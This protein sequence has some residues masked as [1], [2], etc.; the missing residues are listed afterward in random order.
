M[1]IL[2]RGKRQ[3][4]LPVS[5]QGEVCQNKVCTSANRYL[6]QLDKLMT[7]CWVNL[8]Q[9]LVFFDSLDKSMPALRVRAK[10]LQPGRRYEDFCLIRTFRRKQRLNRQDISSAKRCGGINQSAIKE[11]PTGIA[12]HALKV[13]RCHVNRALGKGRHVNPG[14]RF[15]ILRQFFLHDPAP[16]LRDC[17]EAAP[18]ELI[19]QCGLTSTGAPRDDDAASQIKGCSANARHPQRASNRS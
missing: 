3:L 5:A 18:R 6:G 7:V 16:R 8:H 13:V 1:R 17:P 11:H 14:Q 12:L 15:T 9:P 4:V 10:N 2:K 19:Q